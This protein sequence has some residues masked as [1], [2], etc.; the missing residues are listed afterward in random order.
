MTPEL[1]KSVTEGAETVQQLAEKFVPE[2]DAFFNTIGEEFP[3]AAEGKFRPSYLQDAGKALAK[4]SSFA[5]W[6]RKQIKT[7]DEQ[8]AGLIKVRDIT[9]KVLWVHNSFRT[10]FEKTAP[11]MK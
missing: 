8:F 9:G 6:L 10:Q 1:E 11:S 5:H 2:D 7:K 4:E 3:T